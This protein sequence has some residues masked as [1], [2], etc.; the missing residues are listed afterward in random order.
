MDSSNKFEESF[1]PTK[2][3]EKTFK[4]PVERPVSRFALD[5]LHKF[6]STKYF[7]QSQGET[8]KILDYGCGPVIANII[9]A[10]GLTDFDVQ[11][12][13]AEFTENSRKAVQQWLDGEPS[14]WNWRPY[15]NYIVHTL[16]GKE[17]KEALKR[18][19]S[20]RKAIKGVVPCDITRDPP[21]ATEFQGPYDI[22]MS[23]LCIENGCQTRD[24][25]RAAIRKVAGLIKVEGTLLLYSTVRNKDGQGYYHVG[26]TK[27]V[28]VALP[29]HFVE[30]TLTEAG[31]VGITKNIFAEKE[32]I[33]AYNDEGSDLETVAFITATKK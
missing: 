20:L 5:N 19:E 17:S 13:L 23:M 31:F 22:V 24:D 21:I 9:S 26:T 12:T 11:C 8:L 15:F 6:F 32:S 7:S 29:L 10:A 4:S 25:Y 1:D 18:E 3:L 27:Y 30:T 33:I 28:Q 14:A 16:E 2:Y